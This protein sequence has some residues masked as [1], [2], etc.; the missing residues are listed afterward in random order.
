MATKEPTTDDL[1]RKRMLEL[2]AERDKTNADLAPLRAKC[3]EVHQQIQGLYDT[4]AP[5]GQQIKAR[6]PRQQQVENEIAKLA[7]ALGG[8]SMSDRG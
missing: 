2:M 3:D 8:K 1:L 7:K 5:L 6:M 4:I